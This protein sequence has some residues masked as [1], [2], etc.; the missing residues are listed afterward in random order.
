MQNYYNLR[1]NQQPPQ[2]YWRFWVIVAGRGFGKTLAGAHCILNFIRSQ[3]KIS[4]GLL[5]ASIKEVKNVMLW[6]NS[7]LLTLCNIYGIDFKTFWSDNKI[8][9]DKTT[10][11]LFSA[12]KPDNLR[13]FSMD[14]V[15]IDELAKFN[16]PQEV[17]NQVILSTR[18]GDPQFIITTTPKPL[19]IFEFLK[20]QDYNFWS[21]GSSYDNKEFL[22]ASYF[23]LIDQWKNTP[24]GRQE[25]YGE[26]LITN[27][28]PWSNYCFQYKN[29][30]HLNNYVLSIDPG[31][32]K[33]GNTTGIILAAYDIILNKIIILEDFSLQ[34]SVEN[35]IQYVVKICQQYPIGTIAIETNQGGDLLEYALNKDLN[36]TINIVKFFAHH[37][38]FSRS[39]AA[40]QLYWQNFIFHQKPLPLLEQEL[41]EFEGSLDRVDSLI[42]AIEFLINNINKN[43]ILNHDIWFCL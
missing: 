10:I 11:Y 36:K 7:G 5:G 4:I 28:S 37:N 19:K 25:I 14:C 2:E 26:I 29:S 24:L 30:L 21:R 33:N 12:E 1:F 41:L 35:W 6:G 3:Q 43:H 42:W 22:P 13:G 31:I 8:I 27:P 23:N 17:L 39:L 38:K 40:A 9:I 15:W 20:S 18:L 34:N 16:G 32:V